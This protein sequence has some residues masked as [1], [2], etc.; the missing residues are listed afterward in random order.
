MDSVV[1]KTLNEHTDKEGKIYGAWIIQYFE[2][3]KSISVKIVVGKKKVK[4]DGS[5]WYVASGLN[6]KDFK[7]V[8]EHWAE[9]VKLSDNPPEPPVAAPPPPDDNGDV[10]NV[11]F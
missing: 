11:P 7:L 4:D 3:A 10:E 2:G 9:Y 8:K 1:L 6:R 5:I